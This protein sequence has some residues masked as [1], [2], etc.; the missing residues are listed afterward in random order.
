MDKNALKR[1][2]EQLLISDVFVR[3]ATLRANPDVDPKMSKNLTLGVQFRHTL[4]EDAQQVEATVSDGSKA[5]FVRLHFDTGVRLIDATDGKPIPKDGE[6]PT[7]RV[8]G[9]VQVTFVA[10]YRVKDGKMLDEA[11]LGA[12]AQHNAMYHVW[13]YW[14]ELAQTAFHRMR[15]PEVVLP[16]H[17][18]ARNAPDAPDAV[19]P[20]RVA[21]R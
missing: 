20:A 12:F 17:F 21:E 14:R 1:A 11:A 9:E 10:E 13:P 4:V 19:E 8:C 2:Q 6:V 16:M 3:E 7:E 5:L 18:V 15:F